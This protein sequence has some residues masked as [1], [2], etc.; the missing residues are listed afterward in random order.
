MGF[1]LTPSLNKYKT[2]EHEMPDADGMA[3]THMLGTVEVISK[4]TKNTHN[5]SPSGD[6][7]TNRHFVRNKKWMRYYIIIIPHYDT[8]LK[9][10]S[11]L[12]R[13]CPALRNVV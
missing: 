12:S 11:R 4:H 7:L 6:N 1:H 5:E 2:V 13:R 8:N 3:H 10:V 9:F